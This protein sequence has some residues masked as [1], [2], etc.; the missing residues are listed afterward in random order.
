MTI[1]RTR[2]LLPVLAMALLTVA[3]CSGSDDPKPKATKGSSAPTADVDEA[4]ACALLTP[5][6]RRRLAG[7]AVDTVLTSDAREGGS[8]QCRWQADN[9]LVQVT[10][11]PA[12]AWATSLPDVVA[13]L[14]TSR[15]QDS[16]TDRKDLARA[17]KLLAGADSF[18]NAEA[19]SAFTTLAEI[20][21]AKRGATTTITP[22][23][24]TETEVGLSAQICAKGQLTSIIYSVPGLEETPKVDRTVTSV[25]RS[26][27]RRVLA[28]S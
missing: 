23:P 7:M 19:C 8:S 9:A 22:V 1:S 27:H 15:Q 12:K 28:V 24:I 13:Q 25:L 14:E 4:A 20:G 26:A 17:K 21:G 11:L 5:A 10:T 16:T 2:T 6:D 18:T 3:G